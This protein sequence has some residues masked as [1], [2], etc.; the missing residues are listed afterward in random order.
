MTKYKLTFND[1]VHVFD[2]DAFLLDGKKLQGQEYSLLCRLVS[3]KGSYI[4]KDTIA[5]LL[6]G[7]DYYVY[8]YNIKPRI[9][10]LRAKF[11]KDRKI[12]EC[13]K[14]KFGDQAGYHLNCDITEINELSTDIFTPYLNSSISEIDRETEY[15]IRKIAYKDFETKFIVNKP[16][17][18]NI[19]ITSDGGIG[20]TTFVRI[21]YN[22]LRSQYSAIGWIDYSKSL[23]ESILAST[24]KWQN[25]RRDIRLDKINEFFSNAEK[26]LLIID[27]VIDNPIE[28]QFPLQEKEGY[29]NFAKLTG[30]NNLDIIITTRFESFP[31]YTAFPLKEL[32]DVSCFELF[33]NYYDSLDNIE[34]YNT[35]DY[36]LIKDIV[37]IA[38]RNSLL[39][40]LFARAAKYR[41]F[42]SLQD[43]YEYIKTDRYKEASVV[44]KVRTLYRI[45]T[46]SQTQ[47]K[48]LWEFAILPNM[49][50]NGKDIED[51]MDIKANNEEFRYLVDRGWISVKGKEGCSMHDV[52]KESILARCSFPRITDSEKPS[53]YNLYSFSYNHNSTGF[54]PEFCFLNIYSKQ[55][56]VDGLFNREDLSISDINKRVDLLSAITN[57][58]KLDNTQNAYL[59]AMIG[60]NTYHRLG[61]KEKAE[62]PLRHSLEC[63]AEQNKT[64]D[65]NIKQWCLYDDALYITVSY[66]LAYALS[67]METARHEE[68]YELMN[69]TLRLHL[70]RN[71]YNQRFSFE[72]SKMLYQPPFIIY[73]LYTKIREKLVDVSNKTYPEKIILNNFDNICKEVLD[74]S[75]G[76]GSITEYEMVA[77]IM[78]H[79]AYIITICKPN[80]YSTAEKYLIAALRIRNILH[81]IHSINRINKNEYDAFVKP[82]KDYFDSVNNIIKDNKYLEELFV[83]PEDYNLYATASELK[84]N[85]YYGKLNSDF[86]FPEEHNG[87]N[88][89]FKTVPI[90]GSI[91]AYDV[92]NYYLMRDKFKNYLKSIIASKSS[93]TE[94]D[95]I[96]H[97]FSCYSD[98]NYIK[99][100]QDQGTTE[101]NL[102]YLYIQ[103]KRY[104]DA[105]VHLQQAKNIRIR[106]EDYEQKKHLS[107]LSW[108]YNNLGELYLRMY[109]A[110]KEERYLS[111]AITNYEKAVELRI[112]LNELFNDRY[113]DNLAWSYTGLRRCY[114]N[115]KDN[116]NANRCRKAALDIYEGLNDHGQY[117]NDI[118]MLGNEEPLSEPL[119]WVGNQSH[120]KLSKTAKN[121]P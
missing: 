113:L 20:K 96:R 92:F 68:S 2:S 95:L 56:A 106:L 48:I 10:Q 76:L 52:I 51:F 9:S 60:I 111:D 44:D 103:M 69:S 90:V 88:N 7:E 24:D 79:A 38:H 108:T 46:L 42:D 83:D 14:Y 35:N 37:S 61:E 40:E 58:I 26:K 36:E 30:Y 120:F 74:N 45:D 5:K 15:R 70:S 101:D 94:K 29:F 104:T 39:I 115:K 82:F 109:E 65:G 47:Q 21:L 11:G 4:R 34:E 8:H 119:N 63:I 105:E 121:K 33:V 77:R 23:D 49:S 97:Y 19:A 12:I 86:R 53:D 25:E 75:Y 17:K 62:S 93:Y 118:K 50:L 100:L 81:K 73:D 102:G 84:Y 112:E 91:N 18:I 71:I 110:D 66:E 117:D 22:R 59:Y 1:T 16:H 64:S 99:S 55:E 27:N 28:N 57:Y 107:E 43:M 54:A 6:W 13:E 78:D 98:S 3:A 87:Y 67:S 31:G 80:E 41:Y 114:L 85:K 72:H 32:D 89:N 116:K